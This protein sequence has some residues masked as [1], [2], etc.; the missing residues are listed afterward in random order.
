[1]ALFS[2]A[3]IAK[4]M[5]SYVFVFYRQ[6]FGTLVLAPFAFFLESDKA[7]P[8]SFILLCKIF[9]VSLCGITASLNLYYLAFNYTTATLAAASANTVPAL[10]FIMAGIFRIES[11]SI[12]HKHGLAK[13]LGSFIGLSGAM[14]FAF[15]KGPPLIFIKWDPATKKL[16]SHLSIGECVKGSLIMLA[17]NGTWSLWLILQV[18]IIKQYPAKLRL[19]TL[20]C[21]FSCIQSTALAVAMQRNSSAW[22]L[23]WDFNLVSVAYSGLVATGITYW[24]RLCVIESKGPVFTAVFTPLQL[25]MTAIFSAI[26]WRETLYWGSFGGA[27]LLALGLYS[28]LWGK[29]K[30]CV[31]A[32]ADKDRQESKEETILEVTT[33]D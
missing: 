21:F 25:I 15:A 31:K 28:F 14:V 20:Q 11:I 32:H 17:A 16:I 5:D 4:G 6:A 29:N 13:V 19:T 30:E 2:K 3:S 8:L 12:K 22:K 33:K 1:M 18:P 23:G 7:V 24:L 27:V 9:L 10:T 26:L